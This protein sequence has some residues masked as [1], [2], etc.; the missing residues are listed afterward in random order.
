MTPSRDD[1]A[2]FT[3][4]FDQHRHAV[5]AYF[6][7]RVADRELA[8]DL[9]QETFLRAWRRLSELAPLPDG[10]QRAWIFAVARNL[11]IDSYRASAARQAAEA[12]LRHHAATRET[13]VAGP[14]LH[15][16]MGERLARL[17]AA[18]RR[19]PEELRVTLTMATS[20]GLT[21]RQIGEALGE[22]AGT[23]RYR[24]SLARKQL[25]AALDLEDDA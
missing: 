7:G 14:H 23:V 13:T 18:I 10:R 3:R 22:P 16:E 5:H 11:A 25:A 8:R 6:L 12:A 9:L 15:A 2:V 24:L 19:L 17:D 21:S 1:A 20:G 4:I